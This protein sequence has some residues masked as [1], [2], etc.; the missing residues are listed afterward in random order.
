MTKE[1][2]IQL[3]DEL[4]AAIQAYALFNKQ[5]PSEYVAGAVTDIL[6]QDTNRYFEDGDNNE[7][8]KAARKNFLT[9][10]GR[11]DDI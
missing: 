7:F 3:S 9:L 8:I 4:H 11:K 10:I 1:I 2:T 5:P 6:V